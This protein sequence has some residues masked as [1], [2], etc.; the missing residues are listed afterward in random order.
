MAGEEAV[1][2]KDKAIMKKDRREY[3][4]VPGKP[5]DHRLAFLEMSEEFEWM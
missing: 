5:K 2:K 1:N 3:V 4:H